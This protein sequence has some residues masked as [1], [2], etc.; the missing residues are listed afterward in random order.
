MHKLHKTTILLVLFNREFYYNICKNVRNIER[1]TRFKGNLEYIV[2]FG[3]IHTQ[4]FINT[5]IFNIKTIPVIKYYHKTIEST[6]W[7]Y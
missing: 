1:V 3:P 4:F 5:Y 6:K 7:K 2:L